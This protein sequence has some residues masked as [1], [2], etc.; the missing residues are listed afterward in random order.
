MKIKTY[1]V[2]FDR[3]GKEA[4]WQMLNEYLNKQKAGAKQDTQ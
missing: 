3:I 4:A 2:T 1:R